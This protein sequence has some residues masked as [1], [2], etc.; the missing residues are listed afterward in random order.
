MSRVC[1]CEIH[2]QKQRTIT[3]SLSSPVD[4]VFC[5]DYEE[6]GKDFILIP[7]IRGKP[8]EILWKH[9][10]NKVLEYDGSKVDEYGS[11][12]GRVIVDFETG[13][14]TVRKLKSQD[15]GQY[16]ADIV[17]NGKVQSSSHTLTVLGKLT[18]Y[19]R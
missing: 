13:E 19:L 17:I 4:F 14:L 18:V 5:D 6:I 2:S 12:R 10:E 15:S 3:N 11:F 16:Q 9:N 8:E 7:R 1:F